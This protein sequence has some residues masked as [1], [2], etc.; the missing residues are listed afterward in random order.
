MSGGKVLILNGPCNCTNSNTV[1]ICGQIKCLNCN[2]RKD[3]GTGNHF[4]MFFSFQSNFQ[5]VCVLYGETE[6]DD[7][8]FH[9]Q[10]SESS[11]C[12]FP[13]YFSVFGLIVYG[14]LMGLYHLYAV[15]RSRTDP[16]IG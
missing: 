1:S 3:I 9:V 6:W 4:S 2:A 16:T 5:G 14:L 8:K 12:N 7:T 10:E 13:I 15:C 11:N